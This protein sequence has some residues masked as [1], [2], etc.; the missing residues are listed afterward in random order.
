MRL[1]ATQTGVPIS[2]NER[3]YPCVTSLVLINIEAPEHTDPPSVI[4][5]CAHLAPVPPSEMIGSNMG[6]CSKAQCHI[7]DHCLICFHGD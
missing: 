7:D 4:R 2:G 6:K 1:S 3:Q 5:G